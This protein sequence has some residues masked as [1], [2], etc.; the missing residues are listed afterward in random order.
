MI[1]AQ[2]D[3][4]I[5][6]VFGPA[7]AGWDPSRHAT[8]S[9][10][11]MRALTLLAAIVKLRISPV[12]LDN[13]AIKQQ[14][15][16]LFLGYRSIADS[17]PQEHRTLRLSLERFRSELPP[18]YTLPWR[19]WDEGEFARLRPMTRSAEAAAIVNLHRHLREPS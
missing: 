6:S 8:F 19:S 11:R 9:S 2:D 5:A 13:P 1:S 7:P 10:L 3:V 12:D 15:P 16:G 4:R 14:V 18:G 17:H